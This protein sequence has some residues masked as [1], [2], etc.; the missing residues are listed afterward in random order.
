M[1]NKILLSSLTALVCPFSFGFAA[2]VSAEFTDG[3]ST[4]AVDGYVGTAGAG[5]KVPWALVS[6]DAVATVTVE[7]QT[8]L[9]A[10]AGKY[11]S[12]KASTSGGVSFAGGSVNRN[13]TDGIDPTQPVKYTFLIRPEVISAKTRYLIFDAP[14]SQPA[15]GPNMTWAVILSGASWNVFNGDQAG[16][17][18]EIQTGVTAEKGAVYAITVNADPTTKTFTLKIANA[19][20]DVLYTSE[21][22]GLRSSAS[23]KLGGYL[24]FAFADNAPATPDTLGF[25]IDSIS[26]SQGR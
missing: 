15:S 17:G 21:P 8:P 25:S 24:T 22:L 5:W 10:G 14:F 18:K 11:L 1:M 23:N 4:S 7:E 19:T 9:K 26:I 16:S 3:N 6:K 2:P 12:L 13:Y 20:G